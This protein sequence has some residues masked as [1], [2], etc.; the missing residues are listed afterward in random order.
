MEVA[1]NDSSDKLGNND[2]MRRATFFAFLC[3]SL[4]FFA[5]LCL[6]H[7]TL[8]LAGFIR[9]ALHFLYTFA[10]HIRMEFKRDS[11]AIHLT[12]GL[13]RGHGRHVERRR[14]WRRT[15][16]KLEGDAVD[17]IDAIDAVAVRSV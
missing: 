14:R 8:L 5:F 11:H 4:L 6:L 7:F 10:L 13:A 1:R 12:R 15:A 9:V 16:I 3:F 17:A 2:D